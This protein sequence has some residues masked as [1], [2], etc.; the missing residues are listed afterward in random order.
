[1]L[2]GAN[3]VKSNRWI[4]YDVNSQVFKIAKYASEELDASSSIGHVKHPKGSDRRMKD[5]PRQP[6]G[7]EARLAGPVSKITHP[8]EVV[9]DTSMVGGLEDVVAI[10]NTPAKPEDPRTM[11]WLQTGIRNQIKDPPKEVLPPTFES[12]PL[13][14]GE[15]NIF[16]EGLDDLTTN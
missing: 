14:S 11:S 12:K 5:Q 10:D 8:Q 3:I 9:G 4:A 13:K 2:I 16:D 6:L 1:M 15:I 7:P